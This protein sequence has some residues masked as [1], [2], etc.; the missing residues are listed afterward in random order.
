MCLGVLGGGT[1]QAN[2]QWNP[3]GNQ[4]GLSINRE[5][6]RDAVPRGEWNAVLG[7]WWPEGSNQNINCTA[8]RLCVP[9]T[10]PSR[11]PHQAPVVIPGTVPGHMYAPTVPKG[12]LSEWPPLPL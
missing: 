7:G 11:T 6:G 8:R 1:D 2:W 9:G 3:G 10:L 12:P 5:L 4:R